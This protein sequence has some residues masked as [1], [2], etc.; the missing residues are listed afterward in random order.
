VNSL[1]REISWSQ[2]STAW[3]ETEYKIRPSTG[4][5]ERAVVR[6]SPKS[7]EFIL[8]L[9]RWTRIGWEAP[10][11]GGKGGRIQRKRISNNSFF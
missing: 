2:G 10:G 6:G 3:C 9:L 4:S 5:R 8:I 11:G 1:Q 7:G